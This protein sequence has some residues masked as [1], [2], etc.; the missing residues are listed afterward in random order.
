MQSW[1]RGFI[2]LVYLTK[3]YHFTADMLFSILLILMASGFGTFWV[4]EMPHQNLF[5]GFVVG[6]GLRYGAA[7]FFIIFSTPDYAFHEYEG[8]AGIAEVVSCIGISFWFIGYLM[9]GGLTVHKK[10][11][12]YTKVLVFIGMLY[13]LLRPLM[14]LWVEFMADQNKMLFVFMW[15]YGS[16][17]LGIGILMLQ[18]LA[19]KGSYTKVAM[20]LGVTKQVETEMVKIC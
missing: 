12:R 16:M 18:M 6:L 15:E 7:M 13:F 17:L 8:I 19:R 20:T 11:E 14:I 5:L 1:G 10:Y 3:I 9:I 2:T 4:N